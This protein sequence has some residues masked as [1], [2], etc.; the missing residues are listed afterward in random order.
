MLRSVLEH[1]PALVLALSARQ[2]F[3]IRHNFLILILIFN[4]NFNLSARQIVLILY[5]DTWI[6]TDLMCSLQITT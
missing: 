2:I 6:L 5:N 1:L 4:F 3:L